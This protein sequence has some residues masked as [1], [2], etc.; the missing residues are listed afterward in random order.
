[1]VKLNEKQRFIALAV[2]V[3]LLFGGVFASVAM[4]IAQSRAIN[5]L[6]TKLYDDDATANNIS[7]E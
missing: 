2:A 1:M 5:N 3:V 7:A 4:D 6:Q